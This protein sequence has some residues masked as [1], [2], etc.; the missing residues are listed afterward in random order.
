[1]RIPIIIPSS[2]AIIAQATGYLFIIAIFQ[3]YSF[4]NIFILIFRSQWPHVICVVLYYY[5]LYLVNTKTCCF[6][7]SQTH[8]RRLCL[9]LRLLW[10]CILMYHFHSQQPLV[11]NFVKSC[12]LFLSVF[13]H[14][15]FCVND[16]IVPWHPP[17]QLGAFL[18]PRP[19][20][21]PLGMNVFYLC[22]PDMHVKHSINYMVNQPDRHILQTDL[23]HACTGVCVR[24]TG[25]L[26]TVSSVL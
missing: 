5:W 11:S 23:Y 17:V 3:S 10:S 14:G 4:F 6:D 1:M 13:A 24:L 21:V 2:Q 9:C 15:M 12:L 19:T 22:I 25:R 18:Q 16:R 8:D 7:E 20:S 26:N